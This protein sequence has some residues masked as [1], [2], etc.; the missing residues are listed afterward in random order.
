MILIE[1]LSEPPIL[2]HLITRAED[3]LNRVVACPGAPFCPQAHQPTRPLARSLAPHVPK[4]SLLHVS[5]C[6]KGCAHP[7][8]A[9]QTL[10]AAPRGFSSI[11][12]G[13][14]SDAPSSGPVAAEAL[15]ANPSLLN[16]VH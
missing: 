11:L 13:H 5:G 6:A 12:N 4:G 16:K 3:P 15:A 9:P 10:V 14:A 2:D 1:G 7:R 8:P